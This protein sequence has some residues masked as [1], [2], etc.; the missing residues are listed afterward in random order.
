[1]INLTCASIYWKAFSGEIM[2]RFAASKNE[3][4]SPVSSTRSPPRAGTPKRSLWIFFLTSSLLIFSSF[5]P[6]AVSSSTI[7]KRKRSSIVT[8]RLQMVG[9]LEK[10]RCVTTQWQEWVKLKA[11]L[12]FLFSL[13]LGDL[14]PS[15]EVRDDSWKYLIFE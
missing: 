14:I 12:N 3:S 10:Q 2:L 15:V 9:N 13:L 8:S 5:T 4:F 7:P 11:Y 6:V 1:M